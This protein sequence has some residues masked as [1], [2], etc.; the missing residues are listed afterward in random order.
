ML[1][2]VSIAFNIKKIRERYNLSQ[3]ELGEIAGV[4]DKAV[5]TWE[6]GIKTPRMGAIEKISKYFNIPK[7]AIIDDDSGYSKGIKIPVLGKVQAGIPVEAIEGII[8]YEEIT[9]EMARTGEF[10]GL[11][12]R[13]DSMEPKFS[14]GDVVIVR[15]Q[16]DVNTGDI[17]IVLVNGDEATVKKIKKQSDGISL[18]PTNPAY[19]IMF[20]T[21]KEIETLPVIV[22][23]KVVELRAKF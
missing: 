4:T 21:N 16:P 11:Q 19:D 15:K 3:A 1:K 9:P 12:I 17:A 23:G 2:I 8:D 7:S 5:S 22:L 10:F 6:L 18:I 13:G 14:D 20:Y